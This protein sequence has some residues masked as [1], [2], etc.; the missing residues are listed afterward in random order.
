MCSVECRFWSKVEKNGPVLRPELGP[1]WVWTGARFRF[2]YG[3]FRFQDK[4]ELAHRV[5]WRLETGVFPEPCALHE[6]DGGTV[7]CVR[8]SH[9]REG[10]Q[11]ANNSEMFAKGRGKLPN[12]RGERQGHSKLTTADVI[13]IRAAR[14]RG[15]LCSE[16]A[17]RFNIT[18]GAVSAVATRRLWRHVG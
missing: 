14:E 8:F 7:G 13:E 17:R 3:Q 4:A 9:L 5:A 1:C 11:A 18:D 15:V 10:T 2:G 16:L 12:A 6:C